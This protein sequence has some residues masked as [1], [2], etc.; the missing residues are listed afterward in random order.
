[1]NPAFWRDRRVLITGHTGFK[2]SWLALWLNRLG[3]SV[4]GYGLAPATN[5]SLFEL[6]DVGSHLQSVIADIRNLDDVR[7]AMRNARPEIIFHLAA[8][9]LVLESY[10]SP[11]ETL[12]I[13]VM[14][15]ANM[16]EAAR[17]SDGLRA[18]VVVTSDKCY[19]NREQQSGYRE[20]DPMGGHDPYSC[21]K[22]AAE[23]V[24]SSYRRSFFQAGAMPAIASARAGNVIGGGDFAADRVLP[25]CVRAVERSQSVPIRNPDSTR[26]WQFVLEPLAGYLKL[27]EH[28][29]QDGHGYAEPWNFGPADEE[30]HSVRWLCEH[31][32]AVLADCSG[33]HLSIS[34]AQ[35]SE[36]KHEAKLLR[37][38][39]AK[40]R[41][42]LDWH[43]VLTIR[44]AVSMTASWYAEYLKGGDLPAVTV[45][46]IEQFQALAQRHG[47]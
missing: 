40:A 28:L 13:N 39:I 32:A 35:H 10:R 5:P 15:T 37:L 11:L 7:H 20:T 23:L 31:F 22:G 41:Q 26:P 43:P 27:A 47:A 45:A 24:T 44:D 25:D 1:V 3:A 14:G 29:V 21:S 46:Q 42:R 8:Q 33:G 17:S 12:A 19:E 9:S 18:V 36:T 6:A 4:A 30:P 2:G 34:A 38:D 16:L